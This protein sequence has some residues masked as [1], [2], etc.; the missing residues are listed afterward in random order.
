MRSALSLLIFLA[1]CLPMGSFAG[2]K[3]DVSAAT[4][5]WA[6]A[7]NSHDIDKVLAVYD[8]EAVLWGTISPTIRDNPAAFRDYFK[9]LPGRPNA[10]VVIGEQRVRVYADTALNSGYYT[11]SDVREGQAVTTPARFSMAFRQREGRW[12]IVDHHSS[13]IPPPPQ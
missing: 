6:D 13:R 7:Y 2:P 8:P 10:K 9:G 11:F 4:Q 3:E 12:M 5:G 1:L